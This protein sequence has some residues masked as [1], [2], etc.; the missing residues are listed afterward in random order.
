MEALAVEGSGESLLI[1]PV[2]IGY[3]VLTQTQ[4]LESGLAGDERWNLLAPAGQR[5]FGVRSKTVM[6]EVSAV[7]WKQWDFTASA[8][9]LDTIQQRLC[10][11]GIVHCDH[12]M[13]KTGIK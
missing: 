5:T 1:R 9:G 2:Y 10:K 12:D 13:T 6:H 7:D 3:G 4:V 8:F 11:S